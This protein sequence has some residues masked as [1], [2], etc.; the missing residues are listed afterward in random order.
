MTR[1]GVADVA[2]TV[3]SVASA[4]LVTADELLRAGQAAAPLTVHLLR[5]DRNPPYVGYLACRP[6]CPGRDAADAVGLMGQLPSVLAATH[7][8]VVREFAALWSALEPSGRPAPTG[9][10]VVEASMVDHIVGWHPFRRRP[11]VSGSAAVEWGSASRNPN[12]LLPVTVEYL[13]S[14]WRSRIDNDV[15]AVAKMLKR[16]GYRLRWA[17]GS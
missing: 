17:A 10:V 3:N 14:T 6:Y 9:L 4:S 15:P 12:G 8:V 7:L 2:A 13:L 1:A 5:A 11:A 16:A